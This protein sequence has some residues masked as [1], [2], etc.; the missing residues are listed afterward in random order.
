MDEAKKKN[1]ETIKESKRN[2]EKKKKSTK[3]L[4]INKLVKEKIIIKK[5]RLEL[6]RNVSK[7]NPPCFASCLV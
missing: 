2:F 6:E 5:K 3:Q 7:L 4:I 1:K